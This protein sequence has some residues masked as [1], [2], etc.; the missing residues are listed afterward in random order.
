MH[1]TSPLVSQLSRRRFLES[2]AAGLLLAAL[3]PAALL[4]ADTSAL[5]PAH[6]KAMAESPLVYV[7]P[8]RSDGGES[9]C[10]AEVW[11]VADGDDI[12]VVT[13]PER[14][15]AAAIQKG[16]DRA[17]VWIGD[18]GIWKKSEGRFKQAPT[19]LVH[20]RIDKDRA[21]HARALE[22]FGAKYS[23]GW[24]KWGPRFRKGLA[25][26]SRVLIRYSPVS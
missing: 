3:G 23:D 22:K 24:S 21:V 26:G 4:R 17:R 6:R 2:S 9:R 10:H 1:P 19:L 13:N 5:G 25:D 8:L 15:R 18:Y 20:G 12:L 7:T 16:L 11:F 14:W